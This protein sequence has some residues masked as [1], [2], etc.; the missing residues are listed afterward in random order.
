MYQIFDIPAFN[1]SFGNALTAAFTPFCFTSL[2]VPARTLS[3]AASFICF[4][5]LSRTPLPS[6]LNI[7]LAGNLAPADTAVGAAAASAATD[8]VGSGEIEE[9]NPEM[10]S[11]LIGP[12][13]D[14]IQREADK[15]YGATGEWSAPMD[16]EGIQLLRD[17]T[18]LGAW[19]T[20]ESEQG[21]HRGIEDRHGNLKE[22]LGPVRGDLSGRHEVNMG[23]GPD[24]APTSWPLGGEFLGVDRD[25][26][27]I[28]DWRD[29]G[30]KY[31]YDHMIKYED[32][33]KM[34]K[35]LQDGQLTV[36]DIMDAERRGE[37]TREQHI[38]ILDRAF[39]ENSNFNSPARRPNY[40]R[41]F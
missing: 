36:K 27:S 39:G 17:R 10:F 22:I 4:R 37:L 40:Q 3:V 35:M 20:P 30:S 26:D 31:N 14:A 19:R 41:Q 1:N 6:R 2:K 5:N 8:E 38:M 15:P 25:S 32:Q 33:I 16:D 23:L 9:N 13:R 12:Q 11:G 34:V 24:I 28:S 29:L 18:E 21:W 7:A